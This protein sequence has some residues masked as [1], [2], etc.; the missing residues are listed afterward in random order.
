MKWR[1]FLFLGIGVTVFFISIT[2]FVESSSIE[3]PWSN[4]SCVEMVDLAMS[5]EHHSFSDEQHI[6]FHKDLEKCMT[7]M[8]MQHGN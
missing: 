4:L 6:E 2:M 7:D 5:P 3:R 1:N 8:P